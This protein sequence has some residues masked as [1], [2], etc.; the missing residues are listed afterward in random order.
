MTTMQMPPVEEVEVNDKAQNRK[1][2][3]EYKLKILEKADGCKT[4]GSIGELLR[5]EGLYTSHLSQWRQAR[6]QGTLAALS[7]RPRGPRGKV[8]DE[9]DERIT[10]LER[11][12]EQLRARA[13]LSEALV[14]VQKK[15]S[16]LLGIDLVRQ[17]DKS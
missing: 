1:F 4:P 16:Q 11:E 7:A 13:E 2:T 15:V 3:T 14:E 6:R 9:R 5:G 10:E 17:G 8:R 12:V